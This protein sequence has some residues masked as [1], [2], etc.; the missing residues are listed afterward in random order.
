MYDV[1]CCVSMDELMQQLHE[2]YS[3]DQMF[4]AQKAK[5]LSRPI[6]SSPEAVSNAVTEYTPAVINKLLSTDK[7][8]QDKIL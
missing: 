6:R 4:S 2:N 1:Y 5:I 7:M 8:R 3:A